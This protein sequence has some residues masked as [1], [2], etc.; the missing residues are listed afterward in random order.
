MTP[1]IL[2]IIFS[3]L[4]QFFIFK[5]YLLEARNM[6]FPNERYFGPADN[7]I[8]VTIYLFLLGI[9]FILWFIFGWWSM[10]MIGL[11]SQFIWVFYRWDFR[12]DKKEKFIKWFFHQIFRLLGK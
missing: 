12:V 5:G 2:C 10:L 1:H 11:L 8:I 4:A 6:P 3:I 9:F 7:L